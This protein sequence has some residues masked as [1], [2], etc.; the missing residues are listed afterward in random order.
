[1]YGISVLTLT[2]L[3]VTIHKITSEMQISSGFYIYHKNNFKISV[4]LL[5]H[6]E[7]QKKGYNVF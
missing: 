5:P 1:M 2:W 7:L 3:H 4:V 6:V